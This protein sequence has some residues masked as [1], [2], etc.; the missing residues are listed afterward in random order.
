M[1][2]AW[3][4]CWNGCVQRQRDRATSAGLKIDRMGEIGARIQQRHREEPTAASLDRGSEK[5]Q[6]WQVADRTSPDDGDGRGRTL[7]GSIRLRK[8]DKGDTP[9]PA[10]ME[11]FRRIEGLRWFC[12]TRIKLLK[13]GFEFNGIA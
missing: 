12:Q 1:E 5:F 2:A 13:V 4:I 11:N 10:S 8:E 3:E 7:L 6:R 9:S